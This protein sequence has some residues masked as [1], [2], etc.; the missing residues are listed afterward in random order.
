MQIR[1]SNNFLKNPIAFSQQQKT[2]P[3]IQSPAYRAW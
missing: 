2:A 1:H 3:T